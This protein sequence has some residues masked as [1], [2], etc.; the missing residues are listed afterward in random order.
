MATEKGCVAALGEP[1]PEGE[2]RE[3]KR[4]EE[5]RGGEGRGGRGE[6]RGEWRREVRG[7]HFFVPLS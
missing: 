7:E 6:M 4:R 2:R 1:G 5:R 3:E